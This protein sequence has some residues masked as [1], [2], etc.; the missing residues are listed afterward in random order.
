VNVPEALAELIRPAE[1]ARPLDQAFPLLTVDES[2]YPHVALLASAQLGVD[3]GA[4]VLL[5]SVAGT[6]TRANLV[7]DRRA[8]LLAVDGVALHVTKVDVVATVEGDDRT[9]F[10]LQVA[11]YRLDSAGTALHPML[12]ARS[13]ELVAAER[14][15][16]DTAILGR[17]RDELGRP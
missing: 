2:G 1:A 17:L 12:F 14:W 4:S 7:R 11:S 3:A 13:D 16:K 5:A 15:D 8:T 6:N 10:A 9:G